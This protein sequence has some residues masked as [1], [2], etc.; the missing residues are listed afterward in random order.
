MG[1]LDR[2]F[3]KEPSQEPR[4]ILLLPARFGGD[5]IPPNQTWLYP[6]AILQKEVFDDQVLRMIERGEDVEY[7]ARC[8]Y[9]DG[10]PRP[11]PDGLKLEARVRSGGGI[12]ITIDN[13]SRR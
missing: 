6:S 9:D 7:V 3:R 10:K 2:L 5:D 11:I 13:R 12:Q 1:I 4:Q 8:I